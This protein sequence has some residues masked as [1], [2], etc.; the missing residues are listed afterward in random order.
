MAFGRHQPPSG[1]PPLDSERVQD[2]RLSVRRMASDV[3]GA[4]LLALLVAE[5]A[6]APNGDASAIIGLSIATAGA[7]IV[8]RLLGWIHPAIMPGV[9]MAIVVVAILYT[10]DLLGKGRGGGL[11]GYENATGAL[12]V[13]V[14]FA[15]MMLGVAAPRVSASIV[16]FAAACAFGFLAARESTAA[17]FSLG[18]AI[19]AS[20]VIV[21]PRWARPAVLLSLAVFLTFLG[22]TVVLGASYRQGESVG[23]FEGHLRSALTERRVILWH[24]A[25]RIL[26]EHP[27]GVGPGWF[28][29]FSPTAIA[30]QDARWA[31]NEFLQ[32]GAE[33]GWPGLMLTVLLFGWGFARLWLN[34]APD[35]VIAVGAASLAALGIHASVDYVMH[36]A[37]VPVVAA[38]LLGSAQAA[39]RTRVKAPLAVVRQSIGEGGD[40]ETHHPMMGVD[41]RA[42]HAMRRPRVLTISG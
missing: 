39:R 17:A 4:A 18:L 11:L 30:D 25:L 7:L 3:A 13:Q 24:D 9:V 20:P 33:L 37:A 28:A 12:F 10:G 8:G 26:E 29:E 19:I 22:A 23:G 34:P 36:F 1:D 38:A 5:A 35:A 21:R 2:G 6:L 32:E 16:G 40:P 31:H 15:G 42:I 27:T 41:S 14:A